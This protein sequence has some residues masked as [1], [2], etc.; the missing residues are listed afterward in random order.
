MRLWLLRPVEPRTGERDP[1]KP[2]YDK[3]FG[4]VV[5]ADT[6]ALARECASKQT[7]DEDYYGKKHPEYA[8]SVWCDP[9]YTT[10]VELTAD[11]ESGIVMQDF[12]SA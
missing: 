9:V 4:F 7:G 5:R 10:C 3:A 6:E 2:W 12:H 11:G 8:G 1:W